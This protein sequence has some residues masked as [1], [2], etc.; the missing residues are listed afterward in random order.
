[1][2]NPT[3]VLFD[4]PVA[5]P[6]STVGQ[7]QAGAYLI[8]YLTGTTTPANVYAD[9][10]LTTPLSQT[11]GAPQPSCTANSAGQFNAVYLNPSTI[12]RVQLFNSSG[13]KLFD[14]DPYVV[15]G[16]AEPYPITAAESAESVT[17]SNY[18]YLPGDIRR[19]GAVTGSDCT[20]AIN[21]ANSCNQ[22]TF[23]PP[24]TWKFSTFTMPTTLGF[25]LYG[26]GTA[27]VLQQTGSGIV[28]PNVG[29]ADCGYYEG[30]IRDLAF[31]ASAATGHCIN[32]QYAGGVTL[33]NL[34][35]GNVAAGYSAIHVDGNAASTAGDTFSHDVRLLNIQ[36]YTDT[37]ANA[38]LSFGANAAD[39]EVTGFIMNGNNAALYGIY[40]AAGGQTGSFSN[41]H[42]YNCTTNILYIGAG[43]SGFTFDNVTFDNVTSGTG[44]LVYITGVN[45]TIFSACYFEAIAAS[46]NGATIN[47]CAGTVFQGCRWDGA[48][49]AAYCVNETGTTDYTEVVGGATTGIGNFDN[50][51]FN[52]TGTHSVVQNV[53]GFTPFGEQTSF[54]GCSAGTIAAAS[55][56]YLGPNGPQSTAAESQYMVALPSG[57][58]IEDALIAWDTQPGAH[59]YTVT[60]Y[61]NGSAA[62]AAS[63]SANPQVATGA[64]NNTSIV[65]AQGADAFCAQYQTVYLKFVTNAGAPTP[66]ITWAI[67]AV[68]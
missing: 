2:S 50:P 1:M 4:S 28:W 21:A 19:Y 61:I 29:T 11:P 41:S 48:D 64:V 3:G 33:M 27:S 45:A 43:G 22:A 56:N 35:F 32:T 60:L 15:P 9:G 38:G 23:I 40:V 13:S 42:P 25:V 8:F 47:N 31:T 17:P 59:T 30:Y 37:A 63:G 57:M 18:S 54:I 39:F 67:N 52:I 58:S 10:Y 62:T 6:L 5:Q 34:Y 14:I 46:R 53:P 68:G 51:P 65:V 24:G 49:G 55:T 36:V 20:A 66:N 26:V 12:Y 44:D 7:L 16:A